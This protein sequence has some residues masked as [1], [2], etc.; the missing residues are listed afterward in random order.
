[1]RPANTIDMC[2][3]S[4]Q[5]LVA[6][7]DAFDEAAFREPSRLAPWTRA[8]VVAHLINKAEAHVGLFEGAAVG[9]TRSLYPVG[10][11]QDEAAELGAAKPGTV[12]SDGLRYWFQQLETSWDSLKDGHWHREGIMTAGSRTMEEIVSHHL[13]NIEV[14]H[15][16]LGVGYTPSDWPHDFIERE[17]AKRL[18]GLAGRANHSDLLAWL[19]GRQEA[20]DLGPW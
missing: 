1:M 2:R 3:S 6:A 20:P 17:L 15:V 4:H 11:S 13:R 14:H 5:R 7:V 18:D 19:L 16:D 12:L 10:H 9:E 8:H